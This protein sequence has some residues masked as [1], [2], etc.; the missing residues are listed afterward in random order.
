MSTGSLLP[1]YRVR[2][3]FIIALTVVLCRPFLSASGFRFN[4]RVPRSVGG[5]TLSMKKG[6]KRKAGA[7]PVERKSIL[8]EWASH[9]DESF[10]EFSPDQAGEIRIA[11][12]IWYRSN[13]RKLPWRGDSPPFDGSTAGFASTKRGKTNKVSSHRKL[14]FI[15]MK[16]IG[17]HL[18]AA[19]CTSA[20]FL[21]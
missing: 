12:L 4:T 9:Q 15:W 20:L 1:V 21:F 11:L 18:C 10:H 8:S 3:T 2:N 14:D 6:T 7:A 13:R 19:Q 17:P 5:T 16:R